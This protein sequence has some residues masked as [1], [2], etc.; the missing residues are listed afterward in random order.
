MEK[1]FTVIADILYAKDD[2]LHIEGRCNVLIKQDEAETQACFP[3]DFDIVL[4]DGKGASVRAEKKRTQAF[5]VLDDEGKVS[6]PGMT[7]SVEMQT[8]AGM[9]FSFVIRDEGSGKEYPAKIKL[10]RYSQLSSARGYYLESGHCIFKREG[11][12]IA[13][14]K[15][16]LLTRTQ[17]K[18]ERP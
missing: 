10:G 4:R 8:E 6:I 9:R 15:N 7:F 3:D 2:L 14:T 11:N 18:R 5:D 12:A 1:V 17:R 16:S 13:V